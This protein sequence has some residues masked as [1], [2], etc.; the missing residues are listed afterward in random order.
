[1]AIERGD[2]KVGLDAVVLL[3]ECGIVRIDDQDSQRISPRAPSRY[4]KSG[5]EGGKYPADI[6]ANL[7]VAR[8]YTG[9][10]IAGR[11]IGGGRKPE[12]EGE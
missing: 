2:G 9:R 7:I 12:K 4:I 6:I 5:T 11:S 10:G 3:Q 1:M 8:Q